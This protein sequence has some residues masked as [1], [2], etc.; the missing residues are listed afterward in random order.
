MQLRRPQTDEQ[1]VKRDC[2]GLG[3]GQGQLDHKLIILVWFGEQPM[4]LPGLAG[5][6]KGAKEL[7]SL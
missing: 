6:D 4:L 5:I 2:L 1:D 7:T 3:L